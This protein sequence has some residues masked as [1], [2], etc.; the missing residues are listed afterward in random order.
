MNAPAL[1]AQVA[2]RLQAALADLASGRAD[3][4]SVEK[5]LHAIGR[6]AQASGSGMADVVAAFSEAATSA[7]ETARRSQRESVGRLMRLQEE[8][9]RRLAGEIHD[10]TMQAM[11]AAYLRIQLLG[12][13]LT[14]PTDRG[15]CEALERMLK[16]SVQRL[17]RLTFE[18]RPLALDDTTLSSALYDYLGQVEFEARIRFHLVDGLTTEPCEQSRLVLYRAAQE[19]LTNVAKHA[20]ASTVIVALSEDTVGFCLRVE[21]DGRGFRTAALGERGLGLRFVRERAEA[22]GGS[23]RVASKPGRGTNVQVWVPRS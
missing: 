10:D 15:S 9:R 3:R 7:I 19:A 13:T 1:D 17:R 22:I 14:S 5:A 8:E 6:D 20:A 18:L 11:A 4:S 16:H 12:R 21:D 2:A 23:C